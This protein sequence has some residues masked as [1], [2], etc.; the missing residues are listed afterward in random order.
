[1]DS[2]ELDMLEAHALN[3]LKHMPQHVEATDKLR[4]V[5][6]VRRLQSHAMALADLSFAIR[7]AMEQVRIRT[8]PDPAQPR[9]EG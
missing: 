6:E 5:R 9:G 1:M 8:A 2:D 3:T 4:L 7:Q